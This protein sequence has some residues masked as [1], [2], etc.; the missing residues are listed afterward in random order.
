[1]PGAVAGDSIL[2]ADFV[3][4]LAGLRGFGVGDVDGEAVARG[5]VGQL[6][7]QGLGRQVLAELGK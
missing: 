1:M 6:L 7:R 4:D 3:H 2:A 5:D